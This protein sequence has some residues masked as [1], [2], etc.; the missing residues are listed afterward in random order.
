MRMTEDMAADDKET[1]AKEA[2][3]AIEYATLY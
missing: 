3:A 2:L 1:H